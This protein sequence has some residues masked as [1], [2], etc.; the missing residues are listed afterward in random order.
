MHWRSRLDQVLGLDLRSLALFRISMA[1][2]IL[3]DLADR[4]RDMQAHY[5]D[6]GVLPVS[7][8]VGLYGER[9]YA[10][11]HVLASGSV[12]LMALVFVVH[13]PGE[14]SGHVIDTLST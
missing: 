3:Y 13:A 1:F 7:T 14:P 8:L 5:T 2:V 9:V 10:S 11:V 12:A 4:S 6:L